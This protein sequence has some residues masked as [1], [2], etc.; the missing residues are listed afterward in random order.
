LGF[1]LFFTILF[2]LL[3]FLVFI[4]GPVGSGRDRK[5]EEKLTKCES[6]SVLV[7]AIKKESGLFWLKNLSKPIIEINIESIQS[8]THYI[9]L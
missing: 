8:L 2:I 6:D 7:E 1:T 9:F 3:V 4:L 5:N